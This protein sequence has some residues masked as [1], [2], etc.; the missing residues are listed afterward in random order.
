MLEETAMGP[1]SGFRMVELAGIGPAPMCAMLL[2]DL[3]ADIIRIDRTSPSE[4][5]VQRPLKFN[6]TLRGR[7]AVALDLKS[8]EGREVALGLVERA[9]A[10]IEGFRPGVTER[11]GLGPDDCLKRNPGLV[12]GRITGWG[13]TG[14]LASTAGHDLN[15]IGL[16]GALSAIGRANQPPTPPLNL[17]GDFGGG[18]LYLALGIVSALLERRTSGRGQVV[19][20]AI[21]DGAASLMTQFFGMAAAGLWENTRGNNVLDSGAPFYDVYECEYG[22]FVSVAPIERKFLEE[23]V[24][25]LKLPDGSIELAKNKE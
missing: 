16:T 20:A 23:L 22:R 24:R 25:L 1:L 11:L 2:A 6:L 12:Y 4:L 18:A 21:V 14:P 10:L 3:G 8:K 15:Y 19:D 7:K 9:D 17:I 13:Q 5:G